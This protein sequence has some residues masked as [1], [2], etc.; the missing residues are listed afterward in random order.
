MLQNSQIEKKKILKKRGGILEKSVG[1]LF[2][3]DRDY[4]I[5][6]Y[7]NCTQ[8]WTFFLLFFC[9]STY[10]IENETK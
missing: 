5:N 7:N 6:E 10:K 3:H 4:E 1:C 2:C 8:D 9:F